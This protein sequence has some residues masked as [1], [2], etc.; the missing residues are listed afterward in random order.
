[1]TIAKCFL[2]VLVWSVSMVVHANWI[3]SD[4]AKVTH[5]MQWEGEGNPIFFTL[6]SGKTCYLPSADA[7]NYALVMTLYTTGR[8]ANV[9]CYPEVYTFSGATAHKLHR[10]VAM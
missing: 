10:I 7:K 2:V 1:M 8:T 3:Y 9:H 4:A 5:V 6:S